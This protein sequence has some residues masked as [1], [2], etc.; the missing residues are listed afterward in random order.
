LFDLLLGHDRVKEG[1]DEIES[2]MRVHVKIAGLGP[3]FL[4]EFLYKEIGSPPGRDLGDPEV[5]FQFI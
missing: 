4:T 3:L 1:A 5:P 2:E